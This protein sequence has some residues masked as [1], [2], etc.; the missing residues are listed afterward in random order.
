L[1]KKDFSGNTITLEAC[2]F[3]RLETLR[4]LLCRNP[5]A[6]LDAKNNL[7]N[8]CAHEAC[9]KGHVEVIEELIK[10][11]AVT[12]SQKKNGTVATSSL[13]IDTFPFTVIP[14]LNKEKF[15]ISFVH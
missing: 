3:G 13:G 5:P 6:R 8:T 2:S 12:N 14:G 10:R 11:D 9:G 15:G 4:M 1:E 7:L